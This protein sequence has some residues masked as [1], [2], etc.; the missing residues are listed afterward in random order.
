MDANGKVYAHVVKKFTNPLIEG[1]GFVVG[2]THQDELTEIGKLID[3][4]K[5]PLLIPGVGT[6]GASIKDVISALGSNPINRIN[7]SSSVIY[8]F[9]KTKEEDYVKAALNEIKKMHD[10]FK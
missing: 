9:E 2:A 10:E 5:V 1:T 8:A 4:T 6:Q 7:A 3:A